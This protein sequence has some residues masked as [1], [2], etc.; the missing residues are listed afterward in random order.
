[1]Q[2]MS[3]IPNKLIGSFVG[4]IL[5]ALFAIGQDAG[6]AQVTPAGFRLGER[7]TYSMSFQRYENAGFIETYAVSRGKLGDVDAVELRM[8]IKTAG[9]F[10]AAFYQL[11]ESRT[12][13][14][15]PDSG[16]PI[17]IRRQD[18]S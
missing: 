16:N 18:N 11:D 3:I 1:M 7:L 4:L 12:T 13:F 10:S 9:L 5:F 15:S 14:A 2:L 6:K 8:R 17:F